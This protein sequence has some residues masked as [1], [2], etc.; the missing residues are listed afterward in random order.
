MATLGGELKDTRLTGFSRRGGSLTVNGNL[1]MDNAVLHVDGSLTVR[2][3][4]SGRGAVFV[5]GTTRIGGAAQVRA[6]VATAL[7]SGGDT[8]IAGRDRQES[9][10]Q[11]LVDPRR[12]GAALDPNNLGLS[13]LERFRFDINRF[14][15]P[16]DRARVLL[17]RALPR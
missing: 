12:R 2:G 10:F 8:D 9:Q 13:V 11:G 6:D 15:R 16:E 14:L 4:V 5:R 17:C 1:A 7:V 3:G